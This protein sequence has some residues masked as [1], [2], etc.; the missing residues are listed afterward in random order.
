MRRR[1]RFPEEVRDRAIRMVMES[2]VQ[3]LV[4]GADEARAAGHE[5]EAKVK[6][7][8]L[9]RSSDRPQRSGDKPTKNVTR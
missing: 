3:D 6:E 7:G 5:T 2:E 4:N 8:Q 9:K 1:S